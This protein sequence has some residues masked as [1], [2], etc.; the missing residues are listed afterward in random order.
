MKELTEEKPEQNKNEVKFETMNITTGEI[1]PKKK[2]SE[3]FPNKKITKIMLFIVII[4]IIICI[5]IIIIKY[6]S[7]DC[8]IGEDEKCLLCH[9]WHI[10]KCSKCN[11]GYKLV[12]G[13]CIL[14]Y[15]FKATFHTTQKNENVKLINSL[16]NLIY[17][18]I[19]NKD[20]TPC[21][22]YDFISA[23]NHTVYYLMNTK[24][25]TSIK[26]LF[27]QINKVIDISF[28]NIF[29]TEK[30]NDMSNMFYRCSLLKSI[31]L[32]KFNTRNVK[33]MEFMFSSCSELNTIEFNFNTENVKNMSN[34]FSY[35]YKLTSINIA[36]FNTQNV[37]NMNRMFSGC[38]SLTSINTL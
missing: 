38:S 37:L 26:S 21:L 1:Y 23:G 34:M 19:D 24:N 2:N 7:N 33:N 10:N 28:S 11:P 32:K 3:Q 36:S 6:T 13:I 20:I 22:F 25:L 29:N 9:K 16:S 30:I 8:E 17:I 31:N 35:C 4:L 18:N 27:Y 5:I 14:N 15:S 12:K